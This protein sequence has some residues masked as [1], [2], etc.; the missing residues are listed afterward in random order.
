MIINHR[1]SYFYNYNDFNQMIEHIIELDKDDDK[2]IDLLNQSWLEEYNIP[3]NNNID[4]IHISASN[5][6]IGIGTST[7]SG[8]LTVS[9]ANSVAVSTPYGYLTTSGASTGGTSPNPYSITCTSRVQATEF[10]ATSDER[11]KNIQGEIAI[12][13]VDDA[14]LSLSANYK[15]NYDILDTF[16]RLG[17]LGVSNYQTLTQLIQRCR[18]YQTRQNWLYAIVWFLK[19]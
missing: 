3:E 9:G 10:D 4:N 12:A 2:Y 15:A 1:L 19:C 18:L 14:L 5:G 16:Y 7:P 8:Y 17:D 6:N 13:V 11:L